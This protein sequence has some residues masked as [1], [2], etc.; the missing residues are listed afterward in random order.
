MFKRPWAAWRRVQYGLGF[1]T[2]WG[3]IGVMVYFANFY[4]VPNCFDGAANADESGIDCGGG[5]VRICAASV[6]PPRLVWAESF[7]VAPGQY[8]AVA[9]LDNSNQIAGAPVINYTFSF[10]DGETLVGERAGTMAL[11]PNSVYPIFE[12]RVFIAEGQA[13]TNTELRLEPVDLWLPA[14]LQR[15]QF[16]S[17]D[18]NFSD[19]NDKPKLAVEMQNTSLTPAANVE[20]VATVFT[21]DGIPI[22]SSQTIIEFAAPRTSQDIVF[23]WPNPIAKTVRSCVIP[24]D[25]V[26][27]IDLSGSMNNDG[28]TP[29]QPVTDTLNAAGKFASSL[30]SKDQIALVTFASNAQL[31]ASLSQDN[32]MVASTITQLTIDPIEETGFTNTLDALEVVSEEFDSPRQNPDARKVLVLLTDGLPTTAGDADIIASTEAQ[33]L[34]L[35]ESGIEIYAIGLG[36]GV[37]RQF[38]QRLASSE[39]NAYFAPSSVDLESIYQEITTALCESGATKI[40]VIAKTEALFTPLQ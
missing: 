9:Y 6:A 21:E 13:I 37:D 23:T 3:L 28:G 7:E 17:G 36:E 32:Q 31:V 35:D 16:R 24:T 4:V 2:F 18:I 10:F 40:E 30:K 27:A 33:A 12:G 20:V 1:T 29:P 34:L 26:M 15:G 14:S 8:N 38:V 5:C 11:P 25:V 39:S 19:V 22:T